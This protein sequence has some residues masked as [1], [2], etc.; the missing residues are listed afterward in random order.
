M[1]ID[2]LQT[3]FSYLLEWINHNPF[4][5]Y[6]T[7][8][9]IS[10]SESLVVIGLIVPGIA[11]MSIIGALVGSGHINLWPTM[12][13]AILG[14]VV[15]DGLSYYIGACFQDRIRTWYIFKKFPNMIT[16]CENFFTKHGGKSIVIGRFVGPV[17]PMI[18]AVAGMM[19]M[20]ASYFYTVNIISAIFWAPVYLLPGMLFGNTIASLPREIAEK[21]IIL[22]II[23][24]V[25]LWLITKIIKLSTYKLRRQIRRTGNR[26]WLYAENNSLSLVQKIIKHPLAHKKHQIDSFI[27]FIIITSLTIL[28]L[29]FT[30]YHIFT[31]SL[32]PFF[33]HLA[34]MLTPQDIHN[35]FYTVV[36]AIN[37]LSSI[38]LLS[39]IFVILLLSITYLNFTSSRII[40]FKEH[41]NLS[42]FRTYH[43]LYS[44]LLL[45]LC[46]FAV[47]YLIAYLTQYSPPREIVYISRFD[48]INKLYIS[49][50]PNI[51]IGLL[52]LLLGYIGIINYCNNTKIIKQSSF[53]LYTVLIMLLFCSIKLYLGVAWLSDILGSVLISSCLLLAFTLLY[54]QNP[55]QK[56]D[57]KKFNIFILIILSIYITFCSINF[58]C[59]QKDNVINQIQLNKTS[60]IENTKQINLNQWYNQ[61]NQDNQQ[62]NSQDLP[63]NLFI[64]SKNPIINTQWLSTKNNI[65][66]ILE[67]N[68][69][70]KHIDFN[71][72]SMINLLEAKPKLKN[73]PILPAYYLDHPASITY[74]KS[75]AENKLI[76]IRLWQTEYKINNIPLWAGNISYFKP[77]K[78]FDFITVLQHWPYAEFGDVL[79]VFKQELDLNNNISYKIISEQNQSLVDGNLD[80]IL[81][82]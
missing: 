32:N 63:Q 66:K 77:K 21:L 76:S 72:G 13:A 18:P 74:S 65:I 25:V 9:L 61:N 44:G 3:I 12:I 36:L 48:F 42:N 41:I 46:F 54:W 31:T 82:K 33:R 51:E 57:N 1:N 73:M 11:I 5:A 43:H 47:N 29:V 40:C 17:R 69:W 34:L 28:F 6:I 26:V 2:S 55:L 78:Y 30:N 15:G 71:F 20:P 16:K 14:A 8:F 70:N 62:N 19:K 58:I 53:I 4:F 68:N 52:T 81:I 35:T 60:Q 56:L 50:M 80:I 37:N 27:Q 7:I 79:D 67:A 23:I 22:A 75:Y 39:S 64:N 24:F 10:L 59:L 45:L 38:L 49:S